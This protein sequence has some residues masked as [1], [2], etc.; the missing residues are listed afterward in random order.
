MAKRAEILN[1]LE[2]V[3]GLFVVGLAVTPIDASEGS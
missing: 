2:D 1:K 3:P